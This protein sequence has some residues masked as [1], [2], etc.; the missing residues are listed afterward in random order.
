MRAVKFEQANIMLAESQDEY[1]TLPI[2][3]DVDE[4]QRT[5]MVPERQPNGTVRDV[6]RDK[7]GTAVACFEL[8]KEEIDEIV[9]TGRIFF[10]TLTFWQPYQPINMSTTNPFNQ[11]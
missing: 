7:Q 4:N 2:W 10:T 3:M 9:K 8:N 11:Q 6:P 1:E 5:V